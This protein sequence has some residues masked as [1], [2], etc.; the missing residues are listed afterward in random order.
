V[1]VN[2]DCAVCGNELLRCYAVV[3]GNILRVGLPAPEHGRLRLRRHLSRQMLHETGCEGEPE[4][5]YLAS[6][7]EPLPQSN[8]PPEPPVVT[9]DTVLDALLSNENVQ[10]QPT[11]TDCVCNV[12]S[13]RKSRSHWRPPLC[14]AAQK[15]TRQ[16]WNGQGRSRCGCVL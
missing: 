13:T 4:R 15:E 6:A 9:G 7:P 8:A 11:E 12:R 1:Q 3:N 14:F 10:I 2:L 16:F 5:F